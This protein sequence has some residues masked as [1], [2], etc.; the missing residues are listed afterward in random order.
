MRRAIILAAGK[1]ERLVS[2]L[3][4]PKPLKRVA[5]FP[6]IVRAIRNLERAGI[7]EVVV[8]VGYMG[9]VLERGLSRYKFNLDIRFVRN[10]EFDKPNG[11]SLLKAKQF[12]QGPTFVLMSDHLWA[13]ELITPIDAYALKAGEAVLGIDFDIERCV[14]IPDATKVYL[15][16]DKI[17]KISKELPQYHALDTGVFKITEGL[18]E[19][20]E[21]ADGPNGCSLSQ[22]V[23][24]LAA[25]G[26]MKAVSVGNAMWIDVDT[27]MAH[28][29]AERS[30]ARY[31]ITLTP[32]PAAAVQ[33]RRIAI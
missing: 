23:Q 27:P 15:D 3:S 2:G 13:P 28:A 20:L 16:G 22:G 6:L 8:I 19:E 12:V 14:D 30:L 7:D 32:A 33:A 1:G 4:F 26:A 5:G 9:D 10:D 18:I 25:R 17:V 31:G 11:T 29:F 21:R 24:A